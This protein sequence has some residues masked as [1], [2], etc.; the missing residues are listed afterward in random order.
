M[1]H[2]QT[3]IW[4]FIF[5]ANSFHVLSEEWKKNIFRIQIYQIAALSKKKK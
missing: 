5:Y 2:I 4:L 1:L 3:P